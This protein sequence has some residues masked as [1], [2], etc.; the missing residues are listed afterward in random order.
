MLNYLS[1]T[2]SVGNAVFGLGGGVTCS[3]W[4]MTFV[5]DRYALVLVLS[6]G[7]LYWKKID[8]Y[9]DTVVSSDLPYTPT[10]AGL[11]AGDLHES[12]TGQFLASDT[13]YLY[14]LKANTVLRVVEATGAS[15]GS[16]TLRT[17]AAASIPTTALGAVAVKG[18]SL[19]VLSKSQQLLYTYSIG[20]WSWDASPQN[21]VRQVTVSELGTFDISGLFCQPG[22][23]TDVVVLLK[24]GSTS[25]TAVK[26][27]SDLLTRKGQTTWSDPSINIHS[28]QFKG[29]I[30]H[31]VQNDPTTA[32]TGVLIHRFGDGSTNIVA[33]ENT[34]LVV[35]QDRVKA[36]S[37]TKVKISFTV[38]DGYGLPFAATEN[39]RFSLIRVGDSFDSNDGALA[40]TTSGPFRDS[41]DNPL[42]VTLAVPFDVTGKAECYWETPIEVPVDVL[43]HRIKVEYPI[44]S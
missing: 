9:S 10:A 12:T 3:L 40:L 5:E 4:G 14:Y 7:V 21:A 18:S 38:R 16:Q 11:A 15:A 23:D 20:G 33:K 37:G 29:S 35:D 31:V 19:Y 17:S 13:T 28:A 25:T 34:I 26:Y 42:N 27:T 30:L 43:L 36:G 44:F 2:V 6:G 41:S 24:L 8:T 32:G 22:A 1:S 39:T